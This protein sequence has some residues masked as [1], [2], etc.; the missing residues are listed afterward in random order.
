MTSEGLSI[1]DT[2]IAAASFTGAS[3]TVAIYFL[4]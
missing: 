2:G 1:V 4:L 3:A